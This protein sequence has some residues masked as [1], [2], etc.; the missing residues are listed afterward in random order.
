MDAQERERIY[1][2]KSLA[3]T[4]ALLAVWFCAT[5]GVGYFARDLQMHF[6]GWPLGFWVGA[7]GGLGVFVAINW[8]HARYMEKLDATYGM[9]DEA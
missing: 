8:F 2:R 6:A 9:H 3:V 1:W 7:Q 4:G 5:F